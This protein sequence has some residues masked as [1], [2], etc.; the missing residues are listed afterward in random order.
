MVLFIT[1]SNELYAH[2]RDFCLMMAKKRGKVDMAIA[3]K[4]ED[5]DEEFYKRH[6]DI[7]KIRAGNGL[8]LWKPYFICKALETVEYGDIVLYCD[9]G[10]YFF[11][12]CKPII[13][14]MSDDIWV[15]DIPLIE[16][17]FTKPELMEAMGCTC[18]EYAETNQV[19]ANFVAVR[20]TER[21]L[22]F[23]YEW[24]EI[25]EKGDNLQ[26]NTRYKDDPPEFVFCDNRADQSVL[27]LLSKK[28]GLCIHRDPSQFGRVPARYYREERIFIIPEHTDTYRPCIILHRTNKVDVK[29]CIK[30][31][32][33][34]W[35]PKCL[36]PWISTP[37]RLL[38][39]KRKGK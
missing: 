31:W 8:W 17:Q 24:L 20:K 9:A 6:E 4:P 2:T 28:W 33:F 12:S 21:G 25:C 22:R 30:Q 3:Y 37:D 39:E 18:K 11:K 26:Y 16:K 14:S 5:I 1:Y 19:Q 36:L 29:I 32:A 38:K 27:S 7:F 35:I 34:T 13:D 15:S 10:S 23:A